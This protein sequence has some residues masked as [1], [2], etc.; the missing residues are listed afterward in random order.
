[1]NKTIKK[2]ICI[3]LAIFLFPTFAFPHSGRTDSSG[4]HNDRKTG[5]YHYHNRPTAYNVPR[6]SYPKPPSE[7]KVENVVYITRTGAKYH[8]GSCR[9]LKYSSIPIQRKI[10]IRNGYAPCKV[11]RP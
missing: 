3:I 5:G 4:G 9:Y 2:I 10:A 11:C 6:E 8:R 7:D 1:M